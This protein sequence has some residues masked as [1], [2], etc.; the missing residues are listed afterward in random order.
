MTSG[1]FPRSPLK[2]AVL[3]VRRQHSGRGSR[4]A[5][6]RSACGR[7]RMAAP[8]VPRNVGGAADAPAS[9]V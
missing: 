2:V 5:C 6:G 9:D 1:G 3:R 7:G 8:P 4:V